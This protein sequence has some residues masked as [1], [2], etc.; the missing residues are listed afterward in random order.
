MN[1]NQSHSQ[2]SQ[3]LQSEHG[4]SA[5]IYKNSKILNAVLVSK[6]KT[7]NLQITLESAIE[8]ERQTA[9]EFRAESLCP[10]HAELINY[11][12]GTAS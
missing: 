3:W 1:K 2:F 12:R 10:K 9:G 4:R 7:G 5:S 6:Y 8:I 11:L